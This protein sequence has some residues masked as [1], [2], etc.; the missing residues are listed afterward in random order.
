MIA[1]VMV[2]LRGGI[3]CWGELGKGYCRELECEARMQT[4]F[5]SFLSRSRSYGMVAEAFMETV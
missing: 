5:F 2:E 4:L 1:A 3:G